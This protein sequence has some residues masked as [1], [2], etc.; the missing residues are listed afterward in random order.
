MFQRAVVVVLV[1]VS[2]SVVDWEAPA[3]AIGLDSPARTCVFAEDP[4]HRS[5]VEVRMAILDCPQPGQT[6]RVGVWIWTSSGGLRDV[7]ATL[8]SADLDIEG[9]T[10]FLDQTTGSGMTRLG[11]TTVHVPGG[12][13]HVLSVVADVLVPSQGSSGGY[14]ERTVSDRIDLVVR[15]HCSVSYRPD[16]SGALPPCTR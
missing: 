4:D 5:R 14:V 11:T 10:T 13:H 1:L 12:G 15:D 9:P 16:A 7:N 2:I 8:A 6:M 3:S